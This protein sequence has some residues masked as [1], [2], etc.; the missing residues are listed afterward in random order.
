MAVAW[1]NYAVQGFE[2]NDSTGS[3]SLP[4]FKHVVAR[5][6]DKCKI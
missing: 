2:T 3:G 1:G 4:N 5:H 6:C